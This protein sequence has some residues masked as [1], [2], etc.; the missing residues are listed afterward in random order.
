MRKFHKPGMIRV[1]MSRTTLKEDVAQVA[2]ILENWN[3]QYTKNYNNNGLIIEIV[4]T[5][6]S[7]APLPLNIERSPNGTCLLYADFKDKDGAGFY[8]NLAYCEIN[9]CIEPIEIKRVIKNVKKAARQIGIVGNGII[10]LELPSRNYGIFE[11]S[12]DRVFDAVTKELEKHQHIYYALLVGK[13]ISSQA[14]HT[15]NPIA[16]MVFVVPNNYSSPQPTEF[17][18]RNLWGIHDQHNFGDEME[19]SAGR[20]TSEL[21][22]KYE[23]YKSM[24]E[25]P[26][27]YNLQGIS[28]DGRYQ[29]NMRQTHNGNHRLE[30]VSPQL[31]RVVIDAKLSLDKGD[32][33]FCVIWSKHG[34]VWKINNE[35]FSKEIVSKC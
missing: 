28:A 23:L 1:S 14:I 24:D 9:P 20:G 33:D 6:G 22:M 31:G 25:L 12:V 5:N 27:V 29:V 21:G 34:V 11:D 26:G 16:L 3:G 19:R 17:D 15:N 13:S 18:L 35:V 10:V 8:A 30:M 7:W 4:P 32:H 2:A